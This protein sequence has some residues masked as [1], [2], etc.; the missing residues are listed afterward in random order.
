MRMNAPK[1]Y[2]QNAVFTRT[3]FQTKSVRVMLTRHGNQIEPAAV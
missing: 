3:A 1:R 2:P